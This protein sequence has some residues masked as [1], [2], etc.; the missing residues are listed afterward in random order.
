MKNKHW[1]IPVNVKKKHCHRCGNQFFTI[2]THRLVTEKDKDYFRYQKYTSYPWYDCDVYGYEYVCNSCGFCTSFH[3]QRVIE[4]IQKKCNSKILTKWQ[5][6]EFKPKA[7]EEYRRYRFLQS[8]YAPIFITVSILFSILYSLEFDFALVAEK[9]PIIILVLSVPVAFSL[10]DAIKRFNGS[11]QMRAFQGYS[12]D[13]KMLYEK[14]HACA[15]HNRELVEASKKCYCFHCHKAF[16][17]G[18]IVTYTDVTDSAICP[19]CGES[20]V[21]ADSIDEEITMKIINQMHD[22]WY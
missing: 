16:L 17:P 12:F 9:A 11:F 6:D 13:E 21:I 10:I 19:F 1:S 3:E 18:D 7:K 5:L 8:L 4:R 15:R 20:T 14:L 22:Y 2:K